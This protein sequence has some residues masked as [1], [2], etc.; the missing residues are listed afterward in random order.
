MGQAVCEDTIYL[1]WHAHVE[2]AQSGF[3]VSHSNVQLG[4]SQSTSQ[5][6]VCVT[7][8]KH[9]VWTLVKQDLLNLFQHA[10]GHLTM[11]A[12]MNP[13]VVA[14][15][16]Q[17]KIIEEHVRHICIKMLAG[18]NQHLAH[19]GGSRDG[20]GHCERLDELWART[21]HGENLRHACRCDKR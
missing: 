4:S 20:L 14:G 3:D 8:H 7:V 9:Y 12:A 2:T 16:G 17:S 13:Q 6:G 10:P 19:A 11:W 18:M 15:L 5:R 21:Q 1:L